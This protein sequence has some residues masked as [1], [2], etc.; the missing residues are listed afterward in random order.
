MGLLLWAHLNTDEEVKGWVFR[1]R[2]KSL[3]EESELERR[4]L[5]SARLLDYG[6]R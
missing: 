2:K 5:R 4:D 6:S 3:R 1:Q